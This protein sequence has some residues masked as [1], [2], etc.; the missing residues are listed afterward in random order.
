MLASILY[1]DPMGKRYDR[2]NWNSVGHLKINDA[3]V[4]PHSEEYC[5]MAASGPLGTR[6]RSTSPAH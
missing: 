5:I 1:M 4:H 6:K 3:F 2:I